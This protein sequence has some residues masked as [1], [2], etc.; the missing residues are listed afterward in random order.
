[1]IISQSDLNHSQKQSA[2]RNASLQLNITTIPI[3][4]RRIGKMGIGLKEIST[5]L[6]N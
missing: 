1:M 4:K 5:E 2:K 3:L 6:E